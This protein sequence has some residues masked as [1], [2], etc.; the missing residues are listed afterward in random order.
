[1]YCGVMKQ[2]DSR[3]SHQSL[4]STIWVVL[5]E[6]VPNVLSRCHTKRRTGA[7]RPF[8]CYDTDFLDFFENFSFFFVQIFGFY[9][10]FYFLFIFFY[11][12]SYQK[13]GGRG[14]ARP[15]FFWYDSDSGH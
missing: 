2:F 14:Q 12:V 6:K 3:M 4:Q 5:R 9:F 7:A 11:S 8:F 1:M 15:F 10:I 13:K